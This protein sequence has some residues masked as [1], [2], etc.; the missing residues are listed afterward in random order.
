MEEKKEKVEVKS[1]QIEVEDLEE[2]D[3]AD[4]FNQTTE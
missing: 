1:K 4:E 3:A 2:G